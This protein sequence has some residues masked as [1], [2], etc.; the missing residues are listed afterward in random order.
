MLALIAMPEGIAIHIPKMGLKQILKSEAH[1]PEVHELLFGDIGLPDHQRIPDDLKIERLLR[2]IDRAY[3]LVNASKGILEYLD[4]GVRFEGEFLPAL[5][6]DRMLTFK[7]EGLSINPL[8]ELWKNLRN[9]PSSRSRNETYSFIERHKMPITNDGHIVAYKYL[10]SDFMDTYTHSVDNRPGCKPEMPREH[11]DPES[12][13]TCS[14]GYH[15]AS[16]EYVKNSKTI[17]AIKVNPADIV[18]IPY[19]YNGMKMRVCRYEVLEQITGEFEFMNYDERTPAIEAPVEVPVQQSFAE[20]E[21]Q[22]NELDENIE[23]ASHGII[24]RHEYDCRGFWWGYL[25]VDEKYGEVR[26]TGNDLVKLRESFEAKVLKFIDAHIS[27]KPVE[28]FQL[29]MTDDP[30][31]NLDAPAPKRGIEAGWDNWKTCLRDPITGR[32]LSKKK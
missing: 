29:T 30:F 14:F 7:D 31:K 19:D 28:I 11:V 13:R 20:I 18:S 1:Y 27:S 12:S 6:A 32:F 22:S 4:G 21:D 2:I 8:L 25:C 3:E 15:A 10:T 26:Y 23:F 5:I 9:N 24:G 17:V 16:Y